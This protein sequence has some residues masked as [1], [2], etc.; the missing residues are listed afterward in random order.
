NPFDF[1]VAEI[2]CLARL[3]GLQDGS[4]GESM[5]DQFV[6]EQGKREMR[7]VDRHINFLQEKW[8]RADVIF[9]AMR[10]DDGGDLIAILVDEREVGD[11][12]VDAGRLFIREAHACVEDNGFAAAA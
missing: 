1:E 5:L 9:M 7:A 8:Y 2:D 10:E 4:V 6:F 12:D 3:D 11:D